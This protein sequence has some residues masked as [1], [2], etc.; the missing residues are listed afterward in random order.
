MFSS[1]WDYFIFRPLFNFL[2][3]LYQF[4]TNYNLGWAVI[5]MTLL[6]RIV[7]LPFSIMTE[8]G[9]EFYRRISSK[10]SEAQR[11]YADDSVKQRA[12]IRDLLRK[13]KVRPW[14]RLVVL[15]FHVLVLVALYQVFVGGIR[16]S[17]GA[18][19]GAVATSPIMQRLYPSLTPP[20]FINTELYCLNPASSVLCLDVAKRNLPFSALVAVVLFI[21][22]TISQRGLKGKLT[23]S[24]VVYRFLFPAFTFVALAI[25]PSVKSVFILTSLLFSIIISLCGMLFF[26]AGEHR[27]VTAQRRATQ[28]DPAVDP[29][30]NKLYGR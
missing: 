5:Y 3:Y 10:I 14:T 23:P 30:S 28:R 4:H 25:L 24:E 22:I 20:D 15:L 6:L 2:M 27:K 7:L 8:Q 12:A 17:T 19:G 21:E 9:K 11:D 29:F 13:H 18:H 26:G 1:L 16:V